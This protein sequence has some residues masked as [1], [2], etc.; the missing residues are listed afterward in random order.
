MLVAGAVVLAVAS[1]IPASSAADHSSVAADVANGPPPGGARVP[2]AVERALGDDARVRADGLYR[3]G[4]EGGEPLLTHGPDPAGQLDAAGQAARA[5]SGVSE[6]EPIC[7]TDYYQ[8]VLYVREQGAPDRYAEARPAIE[9]VMR[10]ANAA[11]NAS[12]LASGGGTADYKVL[13]D[14]AGEMRV[15][16]A[17]SVGTRTMQIIT[18]LA[19]AEEDEERAH[20]VLFF[21]GELGDV[22][23]WCGIATTSRDE[24]L[25]TEN[26]NNVGGHYAIV[27]SG[28]WD[29]PTLMHELGHAQGAVQYAAPHSTGTGAHCY[30][31][32]DVMCYSPDGGD[33][34]QVD[35]V[36][37]CPSGLRFDCGADDYF[38][39]APEPG[40]YL[41][42]HWNLGSP[43]NRFLAFGPRSEPEAD[44][45][46][47]SPPANAP[48]PGARPPGAADALGSRES[49]PPPPTTQ[50]PGVTED[51]GQ[52][53][54]S[55][56]R[57]PSGRARR[58]HAAAA[59][60]WRHYWVRVPGGKRRL[61]VVLTRTVGDAELELH[62]RRGEK[63]A[64][65]RY[66]CRATDTGASERCGI[67]RPRRGTWYVGVHTRSGNGGTAF[68]VRATY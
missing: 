25:E 35:A 49:P 37:R 27:D 65:T 20:H 51:P 13:C 14:A 34:H 19:R 68:T 33:L 59:G 48:P 1:A 64:G 5:A 40:E 2:R 4:V 63:P 17:V 55:I 12:S 57:L 18:A 46:G 31:E 54:T 56:K 42:S 32:S 66:A 23:G 28:C 61:R 53:Q 36:E 62:V 43:L 29:A 8:H 26:L 10:E 22:Q 67:G 39:T 30:E 38:D 6:R 52:A 60:G 11:L 9:A 15:D 45:P 3:V 58:D 44:G 21:D 47:E 16:R 24:R 41:A 7:A 50:P